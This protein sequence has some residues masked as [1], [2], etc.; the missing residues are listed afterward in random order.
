M[1]EP[2]QVDAARVTIYRKDGTWWWLAKDTNGET[3]ADSG[4]D[5]YTEHHRAVQA[6][7]DLFPD[8]EMIELSAD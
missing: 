2:G 5:G 3:V 6:A 4:D 8:A 1:P 7:K